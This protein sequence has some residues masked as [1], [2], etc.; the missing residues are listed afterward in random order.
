MV[1]AAR[2]TR[3]GASFA[4]GA[5]IDLLGRGYA[6]ATNT[7]D[8][9]QTACNPVL[10]AEAALMTREHFVE[11]YGVPEF[12]IGDGGSGGAIQ[13]LAIAH[14]YPGCSTRCRR[15]CRSPTPISIAGGVTDCG[16][17]VNYYDTEFGAR[18]PTSRSRRSTGK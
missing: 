14:N 16:L 11:P 12:T 9:F 2:S 3:Q 5:D 10:S 4:G 7:L 15:A 1:A 8:T 17:L 18:S 6:V 13:Q